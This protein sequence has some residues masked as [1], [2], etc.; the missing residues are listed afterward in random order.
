MG[1]QPWV[2]ALVGPV[3]G[4]GLGFLFL[5]GVR[6]PRTRR[7]AE[8][9]APLEGYLEGLREELKQ[10]LKMSPIAAAE[11]LFQVLPW[12]TLDPK[13]SGAE[14]QTIARKLKKESGELHAPPWA[15]DRTKQFQKAADA[16]S[17][18][19]AAFFPILHVAGALGGAVA[20]GS[21]GGVGGAAGAGGAGGG[22]GGAG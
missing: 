11:F 7:G 21:G 8:A 22:G 10:K 4:A 17:A 14:T 19:Y 3:A 5:G 2:V 13:Y 18:A 15:V 16:H 9:L 12:L 1:E 6:Y 20:P